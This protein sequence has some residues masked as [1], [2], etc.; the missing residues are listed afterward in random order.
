MEHVHEDDIRESELFVKSLKSVGRERALDCAAGIGRISKFLLCPLFKI[1]DVMERSPQMIDFARASL[2]AE[3]VGEFIL[4]SME[5]F[6]PRHDYDLIAI[7][8]AAAYLQDADLASFLRRCKAALRDN[9]VIFVKDNVADGNDLFV[10][11]ADCSRTRSDSQYKKIFAKAGLHCIKERN[12]KEWPADL[13][14][15]KMYALR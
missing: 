11:K 5:D 3:S 6:V 13:F 9:G 7:P 12:Q 8:W 1:T 15:A 4:D 2:P 14:R 10:S